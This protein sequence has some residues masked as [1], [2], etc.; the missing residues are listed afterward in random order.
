MTL[1]VAAPAIGE[2]CQPWHWVELPGA[3][4]QVLDSMGNVLADLCDSLPIEI[5]RLVAEQICSSVNVF[6]GFAFGG[7]IPAG[8]PYL[9]GEP[10]SF[11]EPH[12]EMIKTWAA[13]NP[14]IA[15]L[16]DVTRMCDPKRGTR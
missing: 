6:H 1:P 14:S 4:I 12:H 13:A 11:P 7:V 15:E 9:V 2:L 8:T 16:V 10:P 5:A 3:G